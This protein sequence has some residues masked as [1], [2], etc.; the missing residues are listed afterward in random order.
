MA[1]SQIR[2]DDGASYERF[3]GIW[4]RMAGDVFIDWLKPASGLK[5]VDVGCGNGAF[6]EN[7]VERCAP[8]AVD[9]VD[10]SEGQLA[11]ARAR[12]AARLAKFHQGDAMALPFAD[13]TFDA[14]VMALVIFFVPEPEKGVAELARVTKPG[15]LVATY[16]WDV[17]GGGFPMEPLQ[18]AMRDMGIKPM[19][20]PRADASRSDA[21]VKLWDGAG[22]EAV[23]IREITVQ[24]TYADFEE[25]W[26]IT[27]LSSGIVPVFAKMSPA[28]LEALKATVRARLPA[29]SSGRIT[30][31][32][33]A[34]AVKGRMPK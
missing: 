24:R 7:I 11:F 25:F 31:S 23:E 19:L 2:F 28:E 21:L 16:A 5:W 13:K 9:G 27:Q 33:R 22:I 10:P 18:S 14:A 8:S 17:L 20:P 12:P 1:E 34:N 30:H 15:G 32:A 26:G 3:M 4:S 6:T 29:D